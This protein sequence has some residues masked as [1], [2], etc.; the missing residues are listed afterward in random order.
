MIFKTLAALSLSAASFYGL[1]T[2][3]FKSKL[4]CIRRF[5]AKQVIDKKVFTYAMIF[6]TF[7]LIPK[8]HLILDRTNWKYV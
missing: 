5:F 7:N 6:N 3:K 4:E 1:S 8:M 2:P